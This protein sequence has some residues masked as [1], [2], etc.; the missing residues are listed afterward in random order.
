[1]HFFHR[2]G[3][4]Q[5]SPRCRTATDIESLN[6]SAAAARPGTLCKQLATSSKVPPFAPHLTLGP[7]FRSSQRDAVAKCRAAADQIAG[8][9]E[10]CPTGDVGRAVAN[11]FRTLAVEIVKSEPLTAAYTAAAA[12][13]GEAGVRFRWLMTRPRPH[14]RALSPRCAPARCSASALPAQHRVH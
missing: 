4:P 9:F 7:P 6:R 2:P 10:C 3:D 14:R 8:H 11:P 12:A 13:L 1:M 5:L